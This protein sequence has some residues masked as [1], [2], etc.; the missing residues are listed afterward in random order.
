MN[1][2]IIP[3][4]RHPVPQLR[5]SRRKERATDMNT[6]FPNDADILAIDLAKNG[7]QVC[8][9]ALE[10]EVPSNRKFTRPKLET[11]QEARSPC[12]VAMEACSTSHTGGASLWP[13]ATRSA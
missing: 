5:T 3:E 11:F 9:T 7:F 10:G 12:P 4:R 8:A 6:R 13:Q 1:A 2:P